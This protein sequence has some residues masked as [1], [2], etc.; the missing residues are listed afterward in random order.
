MFFQPSIAKGTEILLWAFLLF[1]FFAIVFSFVRNCFVFAV[2]LKGFHWTKSYQLLAEFP[3]ARYLALINID[4]LKESGTY[5]LRNEVLKIFWIVPEK[6]RRLRLFT[7]HHWH[8]CSWEMSRFRQQT[9]R[10]MI[11]ISIWMDSDKLILKEVYFVTVYFT[12]ANR[13]RKIESYASFVGVMKQRECWIE[14]VGT[15]CLCSV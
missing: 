14:I 7:P 5:V 2:C 1:C 13:Q 4:K 6:K 11:K 10:K 8:F 15:F 9:T 3:F 12:S